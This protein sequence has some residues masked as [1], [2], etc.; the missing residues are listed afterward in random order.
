MPFPAPP[1]IKI[2]KLNAKT[3]TQFTT[4]SLRTQ[5]EAVGLNCK[6]LTE[7]FLQASI[8]TVRDQIYAGG[9]QTFGIMAPST[10]AST[11]DATA[12]LK[13]SLP[14]DTIHLKNSAT[15][16]WEPDSYGDGFGTDLSVIAYETHFDWLYANRATNGFTGTKAAQLHEV[17][18]LEN[19]IAIQ[20]LFVQ[21]CTQASSTV[22]TGLDKSSME[23]VLHNIIQPL[24]DPQLDNYDQSDSRVIYLLKDYDPST[25]IAQGIGVLYVRWTLKISDY[26]RKTK[27]GGDLH[28][29]DLTVDAGS[30]QYDNPEILCR[31]FYAVANQFQLKVT[32]SDPCFLYKP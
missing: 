15:G 26:K 32:A 27:D 5:L 23:A 24:D 3:P 1:G 7:P 18:N 21:V 4:D 28:H 17:Q 14:N 10:S 12:S 8:D 30:V 22:V 9:T 20:N 6:Q 29:T 2:G 31:D 16:N 11:A 25:Q 19:A 13:V